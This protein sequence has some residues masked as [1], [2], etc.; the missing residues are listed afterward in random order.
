[1]FRM[2]LSINWQWKTM[3]KILTKADWVYMPHAGHL[4]VARECRFH[5]NTYV[6]DYI[7]STVGEWWPSRASREIHASVYDKIWHENNRH[8]KGDTYDHAYM[9][10]FGFEDVGYDRKYET[11]V[12]KGGLGSRK[13]CCPYRV[14]DWLEIDAKG[15]NDQF[16]ARKIHDKMCLKWSKKYL[17]SL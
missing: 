9:E 10:R 14:I 8:L 1:M 3:K 5:L 16:E 17:K 6:G 2:F 15:S 12:F 7:V 11:F 4:I 13:S